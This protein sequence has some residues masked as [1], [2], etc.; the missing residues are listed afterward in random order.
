MDLKTKARRLLK[1]AFP[2]PAQITLDDEQGLSG[3]VR[4]PR[5]RGM[6]FL[7][8]QKLLWEVLDNELSPEER[9]HIA[10]I[11]AVSPEEEIAQLTNDHPNK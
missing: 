9:K 8:R 7:D 1:R 6:D 11:L 10:I 3:V 4:S 5:F 2:P